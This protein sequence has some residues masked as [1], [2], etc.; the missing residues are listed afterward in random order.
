MQR[1]TFALVLLAAVLL[2]SCGSSS[3][4]DLAT[5]PASA[6]PISPSLTRFIASWNDQVFHVD[7]A[8][9][10]AS[11]PRVN[12]SSDL[13]F[14][15]Q[16]TQ[17]V[18][19]SGLLNPSTESVVQVTLLTLGSPG[20][21][22]SAG[23]DSAHDHQPAPEPP[24]GSDIGHHNLDPAAPRPQILQLDQ[25]FLRE[26]VSALIQSASSAAPEDVDEILTQ[27]GLDSAAKPAAT[28]A[29]GSVQT[30]T[31][32]GRTFSLQRFPDSMFF[33]VSSD[34]PWDSEDSSG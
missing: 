7:R 25:P 34:T 31:G 9:N 12:R 33:S 26:A 30:T 4:N 6:E 8:L 11:Q 16:L 10:V 2:A 22:D 21:E 13:S 1:S 28:D 24:G 32:F 5:V 20:A 19:L 27:L 23:E 18:E 29:E 17:D 14:T 15:V 3:K